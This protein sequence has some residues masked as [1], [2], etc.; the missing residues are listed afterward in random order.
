MTTSHYDAIVVGTGAGGAAAAYELA[1]AG[2]S[3]L[4]LEK[5]TRLPR[6]GS[7]LDIERVVH[8]G[9]FLS[10]EPW[11]DGD[12]QRLVPEEHFN[13]GG[14]TSWYG[15]A[16][17][18]FAPGEFAAEPAHGCVG[19]P[20]DYQD[21]APFYDRAEQLLDV[22]RFDAE[23]DL[24][25]IVRRLTIRS[26][27]WR[28][29]PLPMGLAAD[30]VKN[31]VE[32]RHFDG[33]ATVAGL[34]H[35]AE[36]AF[37]NAVS[38]LPNLRLE[39]TAEVAELML[40]DPQAPR[41]NGVR[42]ADGRT[43]SADHVLLAAGA[44][45]SPRLVQRMIE[46]YGL[47]GRLPVSAAV[48]RRLKLHLLTA[49]VAVSPGRKS[50]PIRKTVLLT[51]PAYPHS[52]VQPLGFDGELIGTLVPKFVPRPI[53]AAIGAR[54]YGFFLQTEDGSSPENRVHEVSG[55]QGVERVFDYREARV[56]AAAREHGAFVG[57]FRRAL[58]GAGLISF[59]QRIGL[60][61]TAH[62]CGTLPTGRDPASSVVD[63]NG[64]VHGLA[65]LY[66]VDGSVLPRSSRVNPSLTIFAW[67]LRVAHLLVG[68][69]TS[70][71]PASSAAS[72][73]G[74]KGTT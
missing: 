72:L 37:L 67:S 50:D 10:R 2:W 7:T 30:I 61:G 54:S 73:M 39:M 15:A 65:G 56:A 33:F 51:H 22:R 46:R 9:E 64:Q 21:L 68:A 1:R 5:G 12:G 62:V 70:P 43:F 25:T 69:R 24:A 13:I 71:R 60:Q 11:V 66:V 53:A 3:V 74:M 35:D 47:A 59:G 44:L 40:D 34:K 63:A 8:R 19:W 28:S 16:L 26:P 27:K 29:A 20:I 17:L 14:K 48:G 49:L 52:T 45:H 31:P 32:A 58:L 42:L 6:D 36:N 4:V 18:R 38:D 23:P 57:G 55:A 41:V